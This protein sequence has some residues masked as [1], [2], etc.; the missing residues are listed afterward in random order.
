M[1][2]SSTVSGVSKIFEAGSLA[3]HRLQVFTWCL[4]GVVCQKLVQLLLG[5]KG[6]AKST[7]PRLCFGQEGGISLSI[8]GSMDETKSPGWDV[9]KLVYIPDLLKNMPISLDKSLNL[10]MP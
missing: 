9:G 10:P 2:H 3:W 1:I 6:E 8:S 5:R 7:K 4:N